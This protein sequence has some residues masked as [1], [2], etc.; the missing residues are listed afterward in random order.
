M[1]FSKGVNATDRYGETY[2]QWCELCGNDWSEEYDECWTPCET[3]ELYVPNDKKYF[4]FKGDEENE[5]HYCDG[6]YE[7]KLEE[8]EENP[9]SMK[10]PEE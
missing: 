10:Q 2:E 9:P 7:I 8:I 5:G 3:C 6:C 1:G 4:Y